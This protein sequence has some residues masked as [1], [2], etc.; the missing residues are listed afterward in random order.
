MKSGRLR[1]A[2]GWSC[3]AGE[4]I[5]AA[6]PKPTRIQPHYAALPYGEVAGAI[7][8]VRQSEVSVPVKLGLEFLVLTACRS[9]EVR[10]AR[11]EEI[12]VEGGEWTI[13]PERMKHKRE[14]RVP[15]AERAREI[16]AE[17]KEHTAGPEWVFP[18]P[19]GLQ[20]K[21]FNFS[22]VLRELGIAAVPHGFRSSF[23]D[24][25][26]ECNGRAP[27]SHGGSA[28]A[29]R[30]EQGGGRLRPLGPLRAAT[31]PDGRL[32]R[33]LGPCGLDTLSR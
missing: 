27:C 24:W 21:D 12:D 22:G 7:E 17:A 4:A 32:G 29:R 25:A 5:G 15:L 2:I 20:L 9:G 30:P 33:L 31:R 28:V 8:A 14:H 3:P 1:K 18:S 11:W 13:P 16:L 19:M 26:A 10:G 23:R 6:L